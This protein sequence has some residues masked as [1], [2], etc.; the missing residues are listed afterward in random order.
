MKVG[1]ATGFEAL[2][3]RVKLELDKKRIES[4]IIGYRKFFFD[5]IEEKFDVVVLSKNL[6]QES[7][8]KLNDL[9]YA[10][11]KSGIR[12]IFLSSKDEED[13]E[14]V[15]KCM[16][17]S[18][19]DLLFDPIDPEQVVELIEKPNTFADISDIYNRYKDVKVTGGNKISIPRVSKQSTSSMEAKPKVK[20]KVVKKVVEK[21]VEKPVVVEKTVYKIRNM[22]SRILAF[23]TT[24]NAF[25]TAD[26]ITQLSVLLSKKTDQKILVVDFNT[27]FPVMDQFLETKKSTD[28]QSEYD[29]GDNTSI[30]A[31]YNAMDRNIFNSDVFSKL[32]VHHPKYKKLD[33][34]TG[35]NDL[36]LFQSLDE[37]HY[38]KILEAAAE[39]DYNSIFI[40]TNPDIGLAGTLVSIENATDVIC[41]CEGNYT[42]MSNLLF[43]I[44]NLKKRI[45]SKRIKIVI[46]NTSGTSL[47]KETIEKVFEGYQVIGYI[48]FEKE[49]ESSLNDGKVFISHAPEKKILPYTKI[50]ESLGYLP[51][52]SFM[53]RLFKKNTGKGRERRK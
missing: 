4:N 46:M 41:L 28:V 47:D 32:V 48:P 15:K 35:S 11:R 12:I 7:E 43:M 21:V 31:M 29:I 37:A 42:S 1:I 51:K 45:E 16:D 19:Y 38:R 25:L 9:L 17:L 34:V 49:K 50:I 24:D 18:V 3:N 53:D 40:N 2:D 14:D 33:V 5:N 30:E 27:L 44:S 13:S 6:P 22:K 8:V 52:T 39:N 23:Y 36:V 26:L 10:L 20:T